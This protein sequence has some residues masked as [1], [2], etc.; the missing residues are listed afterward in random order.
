MYSSVSFTFNWL[1]L[2]QNWLVARYISID[3]S[4]YGHKSHWPMIYHN[5]FKDEK[6]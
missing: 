3:A 1:G 6:G 5:L 4:R 2:P